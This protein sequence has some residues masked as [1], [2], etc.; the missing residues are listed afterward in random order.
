[1]HQT[2]FGI[3]IIVFVIFTPVFTFFVL[4]SIFILSAVL[5][6]NKLSVYY[7]HV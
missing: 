1:M 5:E 2:I 4:F 6:S 3:V 7:M